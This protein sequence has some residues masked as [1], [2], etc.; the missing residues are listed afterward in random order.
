MHNRAD[1]LVAWDGSNSLLAALG[2]GAIAMNWQ[3]A[4]LTM[5][6]CVVI[7]NN[8]AS[9]SGG[10]LLSYQNPIFIGTRKSLAECVSLCG[11]HQQ[12]PSCY[13]GTWQPAAMEALLADSCHMHPSFPELT[14]LR[15]ANS[16]SSRA[17][18]Q[19]G[20]SNGSQGW[21]RLPGLLIVGNE[22]DSGGCICLQG[23]AH[24]LAIDGANSTSSWI[25]D[26]AILCN[27]GRISA[28]GLSFT[29]ARGTVELNNAVVAFNM[30][31]FGAGMVVGGGAS[32]ICSGTT[33]I[34]GNMASSG[35]AYAGG[36]YVQGALVLKDQTVVERNEAVL[37]GGGVALEYT[38]SL[39]IEG[40][41]EVRFNKAS[42]GGGLAFAN[43]L[44]TQFES[45]D[46][47]KSVHDNE[48]D[49][50]KNMYLPPR[51]FSTMLVASDGR[52][53]QVNKTFVVDTVSRVPRDQGLLPLV[54]HVTSHNSLPVAGALVRITLGTSEL[55]GGFRKTNASGVADFFDLKVRAPPGLYNITITRLDWFFSP[56]PMHMLV[57][58]RSCVVGEVTQSLPDACEPWAQGSYSLDPAN[59]SCDACPE[60]ALCPGRSALLPLPGFY[61]SSDQSN[62]FHR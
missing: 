60:G 29:A 62:Q 17:L 19:K 20:I 12:A 31:P 53:F 54:V 39:A 3:Y 13:Q 44:G 23:Y 28:G 5:N 48:A 2:G 59:A 45:Y 26:T 58:V 6:S 43:W 36:V 40:Q 1:K 52:Q 24:Q 22:A 32:A 56:K 10:G 9:L 51:N 4:T 18:L 61:H 25:A 7:A 14:K 33:V 34:S 27:S 16:N 11:R 38:A 49:T 47:H 30:A 21:G 15:H 57:R 42:T 8:S 37:Y 50:A 41:A 35:R 46:M 55:L